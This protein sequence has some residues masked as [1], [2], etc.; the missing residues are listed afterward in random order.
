MNSTT[1]TR[2]KGAEV[3]RIRELVLPSDQTTPV[4]ECDNCHMDISRQVRI[5][6]CTFLY[7][8]LFFLD[9]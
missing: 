5:R 2:R 8:L 9:G 3:S 7:R 1:V 4:Y 6:C